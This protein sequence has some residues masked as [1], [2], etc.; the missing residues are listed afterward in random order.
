MAGKVE[1]PLAGRT[2]GIY[3][4]GYRGS[5]SGTMFCATTRVNFSLTKP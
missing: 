4:M 5:D 1:K 3:Y 2:Q